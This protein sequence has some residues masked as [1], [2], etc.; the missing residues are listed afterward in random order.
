MYTFLTVEKHQPENRGK[1]GIGS[2]LLLVRIIIFSLGL[3][4]AFA[5]SGIPIDK[6]AIIFSALS[7]GIGFGLQTLVNNLVS[8]L[9]IAFEKPLNV[10]DLVDINGQSGIMKSIGFRSS[11]LSTWDGSDVIIPNGDMLNAHLINWTLS[12]TK[13]RADIKIGVAYSADLAQIKSLL[14]AVLNEDPRV[15]KYPASSIIFR[16]FGSSAVEC[17][18]LFWIDTVMHPWIFI[19][20]DII[21]AIDKQ[22][23]KEGI[24]IP[25]PQQDIYIKTVEG[26]P[27]NNQNQKLE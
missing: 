14:E 25:F 19:K 4:F 24:E 17:S 8:G 10:G 26:K 23:K 20:S 18:V 1:K 27:V 3:F 2:L 16:E 22:F 12:D 21:Q 7:V 15:L 5:A 6:M 11:V 13:R 9:I